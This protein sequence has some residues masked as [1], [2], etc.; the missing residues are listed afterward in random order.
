[1][2]APLHRW[3]QAARARFR[4]LCRGSVSAW[5]SET[6]KCRARLAPFCTGYGVDL[7][8]GGDPITGDAIRV[9]QPRPYTKVGPYGVQLGG[10]AQTL[11]WFR[12][13][14]LDFV[15]SSHLLEDFADTESALREWLRVL[16]PGGKLV[17]FC[18]DEQVYRRHCAATGQPLNPHHVHA[19]FS[20]RYIKHL[21]PRIGHVQIIH[22]DSLVNEYSWELVVVKRF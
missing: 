17:L 1:M 7:G 15:Y 9:D 3:A 18:P 6:S 11:G 21:L 5:P 12:D 14:V 20:L 22:E 10:D 13:G 4:A 16:K 2:T 8:C 19:E